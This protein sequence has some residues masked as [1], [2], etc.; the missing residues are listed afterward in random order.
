MELLIF[1]AIIIACAAAY[2]ACI[3]Y[4]FLKRTDLSSLHG[5]GFV[6]NKGEKGIAA[7]AVVT[8]LSGLAFSVL[9]AIF[10]FKSKF[11]TGILFTADRLMLLWLMLLF[12]VTDV[13]DRVIPNRL[14]LAGFAVRLLFIMAGIISGDPEYELKDLIVGFISVSLSIF[15]VYMFSKNGLGGGDVKLISLLSLSFGLRGSFVLLF[16]SFLLSAVFGG[17]MLLA[18]KAKLKDSFPLAPFLLAG[19]VFKLCIEFFL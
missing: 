18:K 14:V 13:A 16:V 4:D 12:T 9:I 10:S 19:T 5:I 15:L 7:V 8:A 1:A 6:K 11:N 2:F 17:I 3:K